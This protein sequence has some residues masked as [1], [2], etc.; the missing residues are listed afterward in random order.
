MA[1]LAHDRHDLRQDLDIALANQQF[2]LDYQPKGRTR[3]QNIVGFEALIRWHHPKLGLIGPNLF[4]PVAER[5]GQIRAV[6]EWVLREACREAAT[7]SKPLRI[8]VNV[9]ALQF[10]DHAFPTVVAS[11]LMQTGLSPKRLELEITETAFLEDFSRAEAVLEQLRA[12][13][14]QIAIDDFGTG[15][16]NLSLVQSLSFDRLKIDGSFIG[17]LN[18]LPQSAAIV[19]AVIGLA[20]TLKTEVTAE[21][22]ETEDQ[23]AF[24][25]EEGCDEIQGYLLGR[26][27]SIDEYRMIVRPSDPIVRLARP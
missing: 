6:G 8:A 27:R 24:L 14:I 17:N 11:A 25:V 9:S 22:V 19:R 10:K 3:D 2:R 15:Y 21:C 20:H 13:G 16:S 7:W 5:H 18:C 1:Q 12:L 26:P 4:I 23:R